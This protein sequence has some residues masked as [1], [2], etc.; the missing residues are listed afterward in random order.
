MCGFKLCESI[1]CNMSAVNSRKKI[2][3]R[4]DLCGAPQVTVVGV[5]EESLE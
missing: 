1:M 5:E 4:T 2:G 3:L